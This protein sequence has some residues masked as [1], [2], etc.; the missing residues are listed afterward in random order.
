MATTLLNML[1]NYKNS[2]LD[3]NYNIPKEPGINIMNN[4]S[5]D[6]R[7]FMRSLHLYIQE[8][9]IPISDERIIDRLI[10]NPNI[11]RLLSIW[12]EKNNTLQLQHILVEIPHT[13][14]Q[15]NTTEQEEV[16]NLFFERAQ[17]ISDLIPKKT[18]FDLAIESV[19]ERFPHDGPSPEVDRWSDLNRPIA[20]ISTQDL[21]K[22]KRYAFFINGDIF[23]ANTVLDMDPTACAAFD[24][25]INSIIENHAS[26]LLP[27]KHDLH[28]L[29]PTIFSDELLDQIKKDPTITAL[30]A[31]IKP[32]RPVAHQKPVAEIQ[33][34]DPNL[35]KLLLGLEDS[36]DESSVSGITDRDIS[37]GDDSP[38]SPPR[39]LT[40]WQTYNIEANEDL[41]A[42]IQLQIVDPFNVPDRAL[43]TA[44]EHRYAN[45]IEQIIK[46]SGLQKDNDSQKSGVTDGA[47][48][49]SQSDLSQATPQQSA[50]KKPVQHETIPHPREK[51]IPV[52]KDNT[53]NRDFQ[54]RNRNQRQL[55][56]V[57]GKDLS[58]QQ[59]SFKQRLPQHQQ[60]PDT[61]SSLS[62]KSSRRFGK[63]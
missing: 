14:S 57:T 36:D 34:T 61:D 25:Q 22:L 13:L 50:R 6:N 39:T 32:W 10:E 38:P 48:F 30:L 40:F 44:E 3:Y 26:F 42:L 16:L 2:K 12:I 29:N 37:S 19:K 7:E 60:E 51:F 56:Y 1:T 15:V 20:E 27:E 45:Y 54:E 24:T 52:I 35:L 17:I 28:K 62:S 47:S 8:H 11:Q 9:H 63:N 55:D 5:T 49:S 4:R 21:L 33:D 59:K 46:A 31:N 43:T 58:K 41:E 23:S 18:D 53:Q